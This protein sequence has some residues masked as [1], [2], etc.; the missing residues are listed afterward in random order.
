MT[1]R[2][3]EI[4]E[5]GNTGYLE[6]DANGNVG[7]GTDIPGYELDVAG[8]INAST[9]IRSGGSQIS[10]NGVTIAN[11]TTAQRSSLSLG[12]SDSGT[13]IFNIDLNSIEFWD[14]EQWIATNLQPEI[15]SIEKDLWNTSSSSTI[16]LNMASVTDAVTVVFTKVSSGTE[17]IRKVFQQ[18]N[19]TLNIT[20]PD[21]VLEHTGTQ[22][23]SLVDYGDV[24]AIKIQNADGTPS[25]TVEKTVYEPPS[26][27]AVI[28]Y[29]FN[30]GSTDA[31]GYRS[32]IFTTSGTFT[33]ATGTFDIEYVVV[34]GGGA[35]S[36]AHS[37]NTC[38]GG[39]AGGYRSSVVGENSGRVSSAESKLT[40]T[41]GTYTVTIGSGGTCQTGAGNFNGSSGSSSTFHTITSIGGGAGGGVPGTGANGGS[42]GGAGSYSG[43][44]SQNYSGGTGT[45][46]QG[47]NGAGYTG[48]TTGGGAGGGGG[49]GTQPTPSG[50]TLTGSNGG[51]G[52]STS[53]HN[54]PKVLAGG[55]GGSG[56]NDSSGGTG[57]SGG[58]G[59][60]GTN[61][62]SGQSGT[63]NSGGGGGGAKSAVN[64]GNGGSGVVYV[65]YRV[66]EATV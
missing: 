31:D 59:N 32:H 4:R 25:N 29:P 43:S 46:G 34:G 64:A 28:A 58:G 40:L 45:S 27:G 50:T 20:V 24:I 56:W 21:E 1:T 38:G 10:P 33:I 48:S 35:G 47:Y 54:I 65:R 36:K 23:T 57:G 7:I 6:V 60:A 41:P 2:A 12:S 53:I 49:G 66:A 42:G 9:L 5:L 44:A 22:W 63:S 26:G 15:T 13:L 14:G 61:S 8:T 19:N 51:N 55:G 39:G 18:S 30:G 17:L 52:L 62:V 37:T 3:K 11:Y 16:T